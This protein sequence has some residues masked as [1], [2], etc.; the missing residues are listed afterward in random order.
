MESSAGSPG[1][2]DRISSS[3][4]PEPLRAGLAAVRH[5]CADLPVIDD[6]TCDEL[7]DYDESGL[8]H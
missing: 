6:R 2:A 5:Q 8:P 3:I 7:V 1:G 4:D